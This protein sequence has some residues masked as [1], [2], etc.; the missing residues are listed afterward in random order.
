MRKAAAETDVLMVKCGRL[1]PSGANSYPGTL[2]LLQ[3]MFNVEKEVVGGQNSMQVLGKF[4]VGQFATF[5]KPHFDNFHF[6]STF[7]SDQ[8]RVCFLMQSASFGWVE[9]WVKE[10]C[11]GTI[12]FK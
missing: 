4:F 7:G 3:V 2:V 5:K 1:K 6:V 10:F 9:K 12:I 11:C 8:N